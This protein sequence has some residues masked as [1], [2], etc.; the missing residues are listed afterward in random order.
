M[1]HAPVASYRHSLVFLAIVVGVMSAGFAAQQRTVAGGGLVEAHT[2]VIPVYV[3]VT[4]LNWLLAFFVWKGIRKRGVAIG[5]LVGG[6]WQGVREILRD[7]GLA[8]LFWG[9]LGAGA[10]AVHE[11]LGEGAE[12]SVDILLPRTILEVLVWIATSISAGICEEFVFRGYVQR[13]IL[14]LSQRTWIAVLGQGLV[15]GSMHAYQGWRAVVSITLIGILFGVL[16]AWR[17]TLR[18]GMVAHAWQDVWA[19]WLSRLL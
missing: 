10:W 11:L 3:S 19:G 13:Q 7:F 4:A 9:V 8:A 5:S 14:A 16:A 12:K 6:R 2:H 1:T 18:V 15:F 17:R